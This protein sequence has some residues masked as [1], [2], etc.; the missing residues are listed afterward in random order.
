MA[1]NN[2]KELVALFDLSKMKLF[3]RKDED[4]FTYPEDQGAESALREL[5]EHGILGDIIQFGLILERFEQDYYKKHKKEAFTIDYDWGADLVQM[6]LFMHAAWV[7]GTVND[8]GDAY[9]ADY[10]YTCL[11]NMQEAI[12][13]GECVTCDRC[14]RPIAQ[15]D[16]Y[17]HNGYCYCRQCL[18]KKLIE[19]K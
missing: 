9:F 2:M 13:S 1:D 18:E 16:A 14:R 6:F 5:G 4:M 11:R 10:V 7:N 15:E 17:K 19:N 12:D 3:N 8:I